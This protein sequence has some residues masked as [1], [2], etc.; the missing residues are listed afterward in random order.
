MKQF[1]RY[2]ILFL[3]LCTV[4]S[5]PAQNITGTWEGMMPGEYLLVS[6]E[7]KGNELCGYTYDY[8]LRNQEDHCIAA[9]VGRYDRERDVWY[10]SGRSFI[11]NSGTHV[12]MR[13]IMWQD[14]D[15]DKNTLKGK[16]YTQ[17]GLGS[18]FGMD[19]D[20]I[21]LRKISGRPRK[22]PG[23]K[24]DCFPKPVPPVKPVAPPATKSA[25]PKPNVV[26]S[27]PKAVP[28]QPKA[29]P[30]K[31]APA[32]PAP[33]RTIPKTIPKVDTVKKVMP[34][35]A[36]VTIK[37]PDADLMRKM[38][39]RKQQQ[40]SRLEVNVKKINLKVY[41]NGVVDNDTVSIFYNG[42]L[43]LSHQRLSDQAIELN[44]DLDENVTEHTITMFA[45]NLGGIPPN[46]ALIVV[47]AGD[48]RYEL[49]S[50]AS[51]EENAV[52]VFD[53]RPK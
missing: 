36:P 33:P 39:E 12:L 40:Q 3:L 8:E 29:A 52:L 44:I 28:V 50:K 20:D 38:N 37:K 6:I 32:N 27:Q 43:L 34:P 13:L 2:T 19:G 23:G 15:L 51:L 49:R 47:T 11:E 45:E 42:K 22:L 41:D 14:R 26:P 1:Y 21:I 31:P 24:P 10:I 46:T 48:K 25:D 17:S 5:L 53:Y 4:K 9:Y 7:Q 18:F 30:P 35:V 16:V